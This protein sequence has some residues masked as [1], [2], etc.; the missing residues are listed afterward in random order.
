MKKI[1]HLY[2]F[3][4]DYKA[5][6]FREF[7]LTNK[8]KEKPQFS[9]EKAL[10]DIKDQFRKDKNNNYVILC[11]E[12]KKPPTDEP[13]HLARPQRNP[14]LSSSTAQEKK[15]DDKSCLVM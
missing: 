5:N 8:I 4:R 2:D 6:P 14:E 15:E 3:L 10:R 11:Y 13:N 7:F 9:D 12:E 1:K